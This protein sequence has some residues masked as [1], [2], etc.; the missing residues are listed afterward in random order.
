MVSKN[1]KFLILLVVIILNF[2][3]MFPLEQKL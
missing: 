2:D 3:R 1:V